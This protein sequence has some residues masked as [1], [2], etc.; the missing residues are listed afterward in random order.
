MI[1]TTLATVAGCLLAAVCAAPTH[2]LPHDLGITT[3]Q[4]HVDTMTSPTVHQARRPTSYSSADT[5]WAVMA[6]R[7]GRRQRRL[8]P[9]FVDQP[10]SSNSKAITRSK[11][12]A[13]VSGFTS[14]DY[15]PFE[16]MGAFRTGRGE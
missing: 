10:V 11:R 16:K 14:W 3:R 7:S 9:K 1:L 5:V 8:R 13:I 6:T 12:G 15:E 4:L 2:N